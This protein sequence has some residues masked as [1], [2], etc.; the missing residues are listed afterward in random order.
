MGFPSSPL[1]SQERKNSI[2]CPP[3]N[4][5]STN[6]DAQVP[7]QGHPSLWQHP[8]GVVL[9]L[10]ERLP[11]KVFVLWSTP[12]LQLLTGQ[13]FTP[14][15]PCRFTAPSIHLE[16]AGAFLPSLLRTPSL[17]RWGSC[18]QDF[19]GSSPCCS[20]PIE[21]SRGTLRC[22]DCRQNGKDA[23]GRAV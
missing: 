7:S 8:A 21:S 22:Q 3:E 4:P 23:Q 19:S 15:W 5:P 16:K 13:A 1:D 9:P 17:Q 2:G 10:W 14:L 20:P 12:F 11:W 6:T 18:T